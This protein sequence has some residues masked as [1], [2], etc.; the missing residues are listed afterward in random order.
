MSRNYYYY[1]VASLPALDFGQKPPMTARDFL[2][3]AKGLLSEQDFLE[4]LEAENNCDDEKCPQNAL[5]KSW[6]EFERRLRNELCWMRGR[7]FGKDASQY[8]RGYRESDPF[9]VDTV[10]QAMRAADPLEAERLL[11]LVR[12]KK[13]NELAAF[14]YFD[15]EILIIYLLQL[16]ILERYQ[17]IG[18]PQGQKIYLESIKAEIPVV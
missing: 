4:L 14:H 1:F 11:D 10:N 15:L 2:E 8:I 3:K 6:Y 16:K 7:R 9:S 13:M 12:W 5:L 18:S 17:G